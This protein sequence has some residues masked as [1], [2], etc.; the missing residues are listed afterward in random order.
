MEGLIN[1]QKAV[2]TPTILEG[3]VLK[4]NRSVNIKNKTKKQ[5]TCLEVN[6]LNILPAFHYT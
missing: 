5:Q 6:T 1:D 3:T 2:P 4:Q